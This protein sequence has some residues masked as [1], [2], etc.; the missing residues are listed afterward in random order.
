MNFWLKLRVWFKVTVAV[1]VALYLLIFAFQNTGDDKRVAL[2]IWFGREPS[3]PVLAFIPLAFMAGVVT[4]LLTRTILRTIGQL[5]EMKRRKLEREA[6]AVV[7]R[8]AKLRVREQQAKVEGRGFDVV[9]KA[10]EPAV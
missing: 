6:A 10:D 8:A 2:W 5:R 1:A 4:T 7:A 9:P 3:L